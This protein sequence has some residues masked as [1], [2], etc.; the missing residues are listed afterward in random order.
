MDAA[1]S[2]RFRSLT[3]RLTGILARPVSAAARK[4]AAGHLLDWLG[5]ALAGM[6]TPAGKILRQHGRRWGPGRSTAL[7]LGPRHS[8]G[9]VLVNGGLGN[10]LEMDDVHR[11]A[12]LHPGPVVIPAAL[13]LAQELEAPGSALLDAVVRGY[14][15]M[16]RVGR[17]VGPGHYRFW[18]NT[19]TCGPFGSA[20]ACA[21]LLGLDR[22]R[23]VWAL[24][25]A[26]TQMSGFWQCRL[27]PVMTKQLHTA[28][29]AHAGLWAAELA[30][31]DF[32]G[33][34]D[35]LEGRLGLFA[36]TAP[37]AD[38]AAVVDDPDGEWLIFATSFK[39]WPACRH[40]HAAI[41]AALDLRRQVAVDAIAG[42]TVETYRDAVTFC[43][44]RTPTTEAEAKFSL[45]H[46]VA[47]TL[48]DG[49]PPL[50]AFKPDILAR[51]DLVDMRQRISVV[52]SPRFTDVYP[53]HFG[54]SLVADL[55]DGSR[56]RVTI[57]DALGDPEN[58]LSDSLLVEKARTLILSGGL[59][60]DRAEAIIAA[61]LALP[62]GGWLEK[63]G[64][65]LP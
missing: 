54:C 30:A 2:R 18:H 60:P 39:P 37:D 45:Q 47:V 4:R 32:T 28:R 16:I 62:D 13:A 64:E 11:T 10:I 40:A 27:E 21:S 17:A 29:A 49:E 15:A 63:L 8:H 57:A 31:D 61:T 24:G 48:L 36:A 51:P 23:S 53:S 65:A 46:A 55:S 41:D 43:D 44:R 3:A 33:P 22:Q 7:G 20:A 34:A 9:A 6:P 14:E 12:L 19:A 26:G 59:K 52:A 25:N 56:V 38:P 42:L 5:C 58:P 35:I 1:D 50:A